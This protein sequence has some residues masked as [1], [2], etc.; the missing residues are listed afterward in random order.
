MA[1]TSGTGKRTTIAPHG[2]ERYVRR[3]EKGRFSE[4]DDK[5]RSLS[6]D[7]RTHAKKEAKPGNGDRGDQKTKRSSS[8]K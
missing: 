5:G 1:R 2:D 7:I 6:R 3:D 8:R 4:S